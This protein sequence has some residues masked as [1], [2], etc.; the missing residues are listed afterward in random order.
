MYIASKQTKVRCEQYGAISQGAHV[1]AVRLQDLKDH[2]QGACGS[3]DAHNCHVSERRHSG[4]TDNRQLS[5]DS[6][7]LSTVNRQPSTE[8][9]TVNRQTINRQ[10][11][12]RQ[13]PF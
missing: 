1:H 4:T 5:T 13:T 7:Q 12:N 2:S 11:P 6:R 8:S 3:H 9:A 10:L